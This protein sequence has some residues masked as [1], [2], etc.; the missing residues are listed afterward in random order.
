MCAYNGH[1]RVRIV[2]G[3]LSRLHMP[4]ENILVIDDENLDLDTMRRILE[5]EGF[6]VLT[7][8]NYDEAIRS[9]KAHSEEIDLLIVDVSLP[10]R[11]GV[12]IAL[13][14]LKRKPDLKILFAS[15]YVGAEVIRF[16]GVPASDPHFLRKPFR[17]EELLRRVQEVM[18]STEPVRWLNVLKENRKPE[19]PNGT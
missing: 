4:G 3:F 6:R 17:A 11:S 5:S 15:G 14:L 13:D 9:F 2:G 16:Y 19:A 18:K 12:E 7:G 10:G 1:N 8:T